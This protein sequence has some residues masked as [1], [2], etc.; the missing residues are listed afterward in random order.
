MEISHYKA[1]NKGSVL[2][3]FTLTLPKWGGFQIRELCLFSKNGKR[4]L[5][6]PSKPYEVDGQKKYFSYC[7]FADRNN[8]DAFQEKVMKV[9]DEFCAK[10]IQQT[11]VAKSQSVIENFDEDLPF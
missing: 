5:S 8:G 4:W 10:Q 3:T 2:C 9:L 6:Y 11:P 7:G 1:V